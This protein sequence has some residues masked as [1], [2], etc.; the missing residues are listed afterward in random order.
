MGAK[1]V[2]MSDV[3]VEVALTKLPSWKVAGGKLHREFKFTDFVHAFGF[4]T[5]AAI[6]AEALHHHPEW[7]NAY[8]V[9]RID[10]RTHDLNGI[11]NK[12]IEYAQRLEA[13]A[14]AAR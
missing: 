12:D 6:V 8:N 7:S 1:P 13:L 11:S 10:L 3:E 2:L 9:V 14:H 5:K 4:M